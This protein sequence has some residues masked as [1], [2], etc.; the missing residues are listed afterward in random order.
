MKELSPELVR[1]VSEALKGKKLEIFQSCV[2]IIN[3]SLALG[4]WTKRGSVKS[5]KGFSQGI[6]NHLNLNYESLR[7]YNPTTGEMENT[8]ESITLDK[9]KGLS[10]SLCSGV[11]ASGFT[12]E[13]VEFIYN[14]INE[15]EVSSSGEKLKINQPL[16]VCIAWLKLLEEVAEARARLDAYRPLP[17]ITEIGV[18]PRVTRTLDEMGMGAEEYS[19]KLAELERHE[20]WVVELDRYGN[21]IK[22]LNV[23][24]TVKWPKGIIH[25]KSR[26]STLSRN[27]EACGKAIPSGNFV[28]M[29][30]HRSDNSKFSMWVG[31]DCAKNLFGI[32]DVGVKRGES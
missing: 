13:E 29:E 21:E 27:C 4:G 20:K 1:V 30:M 9:A 31:T 11:P 19:I 8:P 17:S 15:K 2:A 14:H 7:K 10:R 32:K 16:E 5:I 18:S 22:R 24:Y 23:W 26:F 28:P 3:E 12:L 6:I 25:N